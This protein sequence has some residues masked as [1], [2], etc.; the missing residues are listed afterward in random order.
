[1]KMMEAIAGLRVVWHRVENR[2]ELI[3]LNT[4]KD[5]GVFLG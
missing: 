1:L 5:L 3:N 2:H 4:P